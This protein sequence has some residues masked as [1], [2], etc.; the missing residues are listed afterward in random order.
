LT[1]DLER[2]ERAMADVLLAGDPVAALEAL[3]PPERALLEAIDRDGLRI[4]A[5]LVA[6]LRF[7]RLMNG[8]RAAAEWFEQDPR[9]FTAA[10]KRYHTAVAPLS[11]MPLHEARAFEAWLTS[12]GARRAPGRSRPGST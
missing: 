12:D 7:E 10:F 5:L 9:A 3:P 4:T 2:Y 1:F 6:R 11:T 8:S